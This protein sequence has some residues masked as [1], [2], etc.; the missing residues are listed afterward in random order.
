M[1]AADVLAVLGDLL[2]PCFVAV[3]DGGLEVALGVLALE[4]G[5][6]G[7][8]VTAYL[9]AFPICDWQALGGCCVLVSYA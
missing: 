4:R 1:L 8:G 5:D 6:G 7:L 3:V 2:L 9:M